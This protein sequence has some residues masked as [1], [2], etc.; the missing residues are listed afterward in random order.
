M[1]KEEKL[2]ILLQIAVENGW[3]DE[4][5]FQYMLTFEHTIIKNQFIFEDGDCGGHLY[6]L[7]DLVINFEE[8]EISF[9]E[10]LCIATQPIVQSYY[11][12]YKEF[13]CRE[14]E[15]IYSKDYKEIEQMWSWDS[16][17]N[18]RRYTSQR[19]E[20]LFETF[21]HLLIKS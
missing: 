4:N 11:Y 5:D 10:A 19:L 7:N 18:N 16:M 3:K 15:W 20:W 1:T 14:D 9:I 8:G 21:N 2:L 12:E 6:S 17:I 13:R